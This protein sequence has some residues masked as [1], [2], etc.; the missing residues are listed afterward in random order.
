MNDD[1][2][3]KL[4][5]ARRQQVALGLVRTELSRRRDRDVRHKLAMA[6]D[7][8][9]LRAVAKACGIERAYAS[10]VKRYGI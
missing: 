7:L 5:L 2:L 6:R 3:A 10:A 9:E 8:R 1:E 4:E